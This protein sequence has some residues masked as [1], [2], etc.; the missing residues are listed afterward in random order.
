MQSQ[1][2]S[3]QIFHQQSEIY[4]PLKITFFCNWNNKTRHTRHFCSVST[5]GRFIEVWKNKN[6][7]LHRSIPLL[8][9]AQYP[10]EFIRN[11][12]APLELCPMPVQE[13][14][15]SLCCEADIKGRGSQGSGWASS[16]I[17]FK[18]VDIGPL[19][20]LNIP[21]V[22]HWTRHWLSFQLQGWCSVSDPDLCTSPRVY[23]K[24]FSLVSQVL[25]I[26][27]KDFLQ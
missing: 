8:N 14:K 7:S 24:E 1:L 25:L 6:K 2:A 15:C 18:N 12:F 20:T 19:Y 3:L 17:F 21:L 26:L 27:L 4:E 13:E 16:V 11:H 5:W 22:C 23:L 9:A 10:K